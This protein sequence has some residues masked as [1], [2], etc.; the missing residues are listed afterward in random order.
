MAFVNNWD[1]KSANNVVLKTGGELQYV[2]SDLG[3][4]FGKTGSN[5]LPVFWRIGRSR[6]VPDEYAESDFVKELDEGKIKFAFNGKNMGQLNDITIE[7]GRWLADL[8]VQLSDQQISD[9]FRA[10]NYSDADIELLTQSV[11]SRIRALDLATGGGA[12]R[13]VETASGN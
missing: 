6:N 9:A 10:A 11:K 12:S 1:M 4:S 5:G 2:I 7:Y 8:L 3:V 13:R